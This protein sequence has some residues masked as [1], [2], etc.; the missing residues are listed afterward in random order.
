[1]RL[2]LPRV[3]FGGSSL[4]LSRW[5]RAAYVKAG[6]VGP[7]RV[8]LDAGKAGSLGGPGRALALLCSAIRRGRCPS[9]LFSCNPILQS[10]TV[11]RGLFEKLVWAS[12]QPQ[13]LGG[14]PGAPK[15]DS[16]L[17]GRYRSIQGHPHGRLPIRARA[18]RIEGS[19]VSTVTP[20]SPWHTCPGMRGCR[21]PRER[22][23]D[24]QSPHR[25]RLRRQARR[26]R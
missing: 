8:P 17:T 13:N 9:P 26:A 7:F 23:G 12:L 22:D 6:E 16:A 18:C 14:A 3:P 11:L 19:N 4:A 25:D 20:L 21:M 15:G 1:M 5:A 10:R 24:I 2:V